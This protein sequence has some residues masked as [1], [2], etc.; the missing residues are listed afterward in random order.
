MASNFTEQRATLKRAGCIWVAP[1]KNIKTRE[2]CELQSP[3][4]SEGVMVAAGDFAYL[5]K[6]GT[7][8]FTIGGTGEESDDN[9]F[10]LLSNSDADVSSWDTSDDD[11][12]L[13][14]DDEASDA[15]AS[16]LD[17]ECL[18][19]RIKGIIQPDQQGLSR[20]ISSARLDRLCLDHANVGQHLAPGWTAWVATVHEPCRFSRDHGE[21]V[22]CVKTGT[23]KDKPRLIVEVTAL[24]DENVITSNVPVLPFRICR[25]TGKSYYCIAAMEDSPSGEIVLR[26]SGTKTKRLAKAA[27]VLTPSKLFVAERHVEHRIIPVEKNKLDVDPCDGLI[28]SSIDAG[29]VYGF[30]SEEQRIALNKILVSGGVPIVSCRQVR[31]PVL[32][33]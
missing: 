20:K 6:M 32:L 22:V 2:D 23:L 31:G 27:L 33:K 10:E 14:V 7:K 11:F 12:L 19:E 13:G 5:A 21:R 16:A 17:N 3:L 24:S 8:V 30:F 29:V 15:G 4:L 18:A 26:G 25:E 28:E 1:P 9:D